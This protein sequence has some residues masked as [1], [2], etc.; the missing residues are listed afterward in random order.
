MHCTALHCT[1][2]HCTALH[3]PALCITLQILNYGSE[4][5]IFFRR[6]KV[7]KKLPRVHLIGCQGVKLFLPKYSFK[8]CQNLNFQFLSYLSQFQF[9][10][11]ITIQVLGFCFWCHYLSFDFCHNI[12]SVFSQFE[13]LCFVTIWVWFCCNLSFVTI[14]ALSQFEFLSFVTI[15]VDF[16]QNLFF[17]VS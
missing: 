15:W 6:Q 14:W 5:C 11:F 3:S 16:C 10:V 9:L 2:L 8:F 7:S 12:S 17:L 4:I 1:A 13:L